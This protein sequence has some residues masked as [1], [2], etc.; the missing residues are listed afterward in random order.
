MIAIA[1]AAAVLF[2]IAQAQNAQAAAERTARKKAAAAL[3]AKAQADDTAQKALDEL[4]RVRTQAAEQLAA[5]QTAAEQA[6][7]AAHAARTELE[8]VRAAAVTALTDAQEAAE[9]AIQK[10][11]ADRDGSAA[12]RVVGPNQ[13]AVSPLRA[14]A[15]LAVTRAPNLSG[16]RKTKMTPELVDKAQRMYDSDRFNMTEI[17]QSCAVSP[18]TIYRHIRTGHTTT[19]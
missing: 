6:Q 13:D 9:A 3:E 14:Q 5:Y 18:T 17:A 1:I 7:I 11:I 12:E 16:G 15:G 4:D 10:A 19:P 8:K 2:A